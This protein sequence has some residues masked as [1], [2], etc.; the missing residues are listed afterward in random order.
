MMRDCVVVV[1]GVVGSCGVQVVQCVVKDGQ[2]HS[3]TEKDRRIARSNVQGS[4][5]TLLVSFSV[6]SAFA[7]ATMSET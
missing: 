4:F 2:P 6:L 1:R 5:L 3:D 7:E